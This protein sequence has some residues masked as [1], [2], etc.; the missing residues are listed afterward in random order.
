MTVDFFDHTADVGA[1]ISAPSIE[2]LF[3]EALLALTATLTDPSCVQSRLSRRLTVR[4]TDLDQLLVDWLS[5]LVSQFD[6]EQFF[7]ALGIADRP[8][9]AGCLEPGCDRTWGSPRC[10]T[11]SCTRAYQGC[12]LSRTSG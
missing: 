11:A 12:D 6:I 8:R 1:R 4:A 3:T 10:R 9:G 7:C 5:E 2:E